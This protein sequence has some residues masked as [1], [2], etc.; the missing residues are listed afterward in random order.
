MIIAYAFQNVSK[1]LDHIRLLLC[2]CSVHIASL[3]NTDRNVAVVLPVNHIT[4]N[5][6]DNFSTRLHIVTDPRIM[7]DT[8]CKRKAKLVDIMA[9]PE[10]RIREID[11]Q[12]RAFRQV[13][14]T[15]V[16]KR[17]CNLRRE[18]GVYARVHRNKSIPR[19]P[20]HDPAAKRDC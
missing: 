7:F 4:I 6:Q 18:F 15:R 13:W 2:F 16:E 9:L 12:Q 11:V 8:S 14:R 5:G 10:V 1:S 19:I 3:Y 20:I 17:F